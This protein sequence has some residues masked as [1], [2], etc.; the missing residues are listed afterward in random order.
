MINLINKIINYLYFS[1]QE[2]ELLIPAQTGNRTIK[3]YTSSERILSVDH[4]PP[5]RKDMQLIID[6]TNF[7]DSVIL[8]ILIILIVLI[9]SNILIILIIS[10]ILN[11][12]NILILLILLII[13]FILII[14][15]ILL[16]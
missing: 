12:L 5:K 13:L 8:I 3:M 4:W 16:F 15:V 10:I 6:L 2:T 7:I 14:F 11:I 9:I 1:K